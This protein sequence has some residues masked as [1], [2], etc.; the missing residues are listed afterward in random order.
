[1]EPT[2]E[3]EEQADLLVDRFL[4]MSDNLVDDHHSFVLCPVCSYPM[5]STNSQDPSQITFMVEGI[6]TGA[7]W[8]T[9]GGFT[10]GNCPSCGA[11]FTYE[12]GYLTT[13][14]QSE[15]TEKPGSSHSSP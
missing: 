10:H 11:S 15:E 3:Q 9:R 4:Q 13:N 1:M 6:W 12:K 5:F 8:T 2:P 7:V 14:L